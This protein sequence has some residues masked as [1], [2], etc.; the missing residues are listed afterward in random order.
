MNARDPVAVIGLGAMGF[1][2]ARCLLAAGFPLTVYNRTTGRAD[3]LVAAGAALAGSPAEAA[4]RA[5]VVISMVSDEHAVDA[6]V[7]GPRGLLTGMR[8]GAVHVGMSTVDPDT[9]RQLAE[10]HGAHGSHYVAAPVFGRPET[11]QQAKLFVIAAGPAPALEACLPALQALSRGIARVG[12]DP[13]RASLVKLAGNFLLVA[14]LEAL[15]E[16]FVFAEKARLDRLQLLQTLNDAL[17]TSPVYQANGE[18]MC[19]GAFSPAGFQLALGLKDVRL[20]L[21]IADRLGVPMPIASL[22][23]DHFLSAVACGKGDLDWTALSEVLREAAG[24]RPA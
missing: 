18:R 19:R 13:P 20:V 4:A 7:S 16:V 12:D 5:R 17:F 15:G 9:S 3:A 10:M 22:A 14:V 11:A 1:P 24:L 23:H 21:R 2:I 6:V 8:P